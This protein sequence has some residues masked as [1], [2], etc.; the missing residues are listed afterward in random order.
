MILCACA[1]NEPVDT[2]AAV[3]RSP[4]EATA[5]P[6][7][8]QQKTTEAVETT[9]ET[10]A[11]N[12]APVLYRHPLNG[13]KLDAPF[14]KRPFAT[15]INNI[16][17]A[18]PQCSVGSADLIFELLAEGGITRCLAVY[19][20]ISDVKHMGSIRS[21]RPYLVD[22]ANS[23]DAIFIHHGG[24]PEGYTEIKTTAVEDLDGMSCGAFYR[25]QSRLNEGYDLEHTSFADGDDLMESADSYGYDLEVAEG[26]DYGFRF[27]DVSSAVNGESANVVTVAFGEGGKSTTLTYNAQAGGY[28]AYQHGDDYIDGNTGKV[29]TF[30]NVISFSAETGYYSNSVCLEITL[31]GEGEGY[32]ACDGKIVPIRWS[33]ADRYEPFQ[34]TMLDGT[35]VTLGVGTTYVGITPLSG[36]VSYE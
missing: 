30:R 11:T 1:R 35:P 36:E 25:D 13:G 4:A 5:A 9:D 18:M 7:Q 28:E 19:S 8:T 24:S 14:T 20:D 22:I 2:T 27:D 34:F 6:T 15:V 33:R 10:A 29:M 16:V 12:A 3:T 17:Y 21:A 23:F 26:V 31:V 32:F